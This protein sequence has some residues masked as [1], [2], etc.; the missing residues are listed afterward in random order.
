MHAEP[1]RTSSWEVTTS[2]VP[3]HVA[4]VRTFSIFFVQQR[5]QET[6][7]HRLLHL[8]PSLL[9]SGTMGFVW[10]IGFDWQTI[11]LWLNWPI[12]AITIWQEKLIMTLKMTTTKIV[13]TLVTFNSSP[14]QRTK[15]LVLRFKQNHFSC[16][17]TLPHLFCIVKFRDLS[18][19]LALTETQPTTLRLNWPVRPITRV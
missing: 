17:F 14:I 3:S 18:G 7:A 8:V 5:K 10:N 16:S 4:Y 6:F 11:T 1:L 19:I 13:A 12:R 15:F 9:W 2:A